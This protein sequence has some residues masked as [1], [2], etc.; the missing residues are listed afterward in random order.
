MNYQQHNTSVTHTEPAQN[1]L[2]APQYSPKQNFATSPKN[3][4]DHVN[5]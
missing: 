4:F 2:A 3:N 5:C 1:S